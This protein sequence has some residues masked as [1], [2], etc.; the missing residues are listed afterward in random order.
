MTILAENITKHYGTQCVLDDISFTLKKSEITGFLGVNGAGKTTTMKILTGYLQDWDGTVKVFGKDLRKNS[1]AI[2]EEI[3]YLPEHNPLDEQLYIREYLQ[4]VAGLYLP[5]KEVQKAINQVIEKV[6]LGKEQHKKIGQLS[7]GYKQRVGL[8][9]AL[10][11]KPQILILDEPTTGLDPKQLEH[12]RQ[13]IKEEAKDKIVLFSTHIMQEVEA[14]CDR[15]LIINNG[16]IV[17]DSKTASNLQ[18]VR[19]KFAESIENLQLPFEANIEK[20][21]TNSFLIHTNHEQDIRPILFNFAKENNLTLLHLSEE[22]RAI[23]TIFQQE[24]K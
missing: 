3:G 8:A 9:Q 18:T 5:K 19:I 13:L 16:K 23:E 4:Y 20:M 1:L 15:T 10:I 21:A 11:H 7:K 17:S 22:K 2:R 12:I 6:A 14:M 24:T